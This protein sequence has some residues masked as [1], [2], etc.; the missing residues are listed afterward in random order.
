MV[1]MGFKVPQENLAAYE[2]LFRIEVGMRE[3]IIE[4]L[5]AQYGQRWAI[6]QLPGDVL[7]SYRSG[8]AV[9]RNLRWSEMIPHHPLYYTDFPDL[10]KIIQRN[11][12]WNSV[13]KA[14]FQSKGIVVATLQG[15]EPIRNKIAHNRKVTGAD[16]RALESAIDII[17]S[18]IGKMKYSSLIGNIS[19]ALDI[20]SRFDRLK[21]E[22]DESYKVC[23]QF[24]S[25]SELE[26]WN[27][28]SRSWWFAGDYLGL[29]IEPIMSYFALLEE[30]QNL[31]RLRG[32]GYRIESW[33]QESDLISRYE[34][35]SCTLSELI[36]QRT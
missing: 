34:V 29:D 32:L 24:K 6:S 36:S 10:T 14:V 31:P 13:F 35:A 20:Q 9:E 33:V 1:E 3:F 15:L 17:E 26:E 5:A 16:V 19:A 30:Y 2:L 11:D 4:S 22:A 12:N 8:R 23:S 28:V 25:L 27:Y 18:A 7:D 21:S